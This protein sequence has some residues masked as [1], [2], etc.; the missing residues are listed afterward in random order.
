MFRT[1]LTS[2]FLFLQIKS[3]AT[4]LLDLRTVS[5]VSRCSG[6]RLAFI[7]KQCLNV[8]CLLSFQ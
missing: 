2:N 8:K 4:P 6:R 3:L 1:V 7:L 5:V